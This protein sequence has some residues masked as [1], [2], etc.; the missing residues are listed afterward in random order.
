MK[1]AYESSECE[2]KDDHINSSMLYGIGITG[3]I[4]GLVLGGP[5][6]GLGLSISGASIALFQEQGKL[7]G[8]IAREVGYLAVNSFKKV[9]KLDEELGLVESIKINSLQTYEKVIMKLDSD[10]RNLYQKSAND[11]ATKS[12]K[13][14]MSLL[15]GLENVNRIINSDEGLDI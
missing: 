1:S 6:L 3:A 5:L 4:A 13:F 12:K 8:D 7:G 14:G 15:Q 11:I 10:Q 2:D 9:Q